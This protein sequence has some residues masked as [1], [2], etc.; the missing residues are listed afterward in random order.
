MLGDRKRVRRALAVAV[1][2]L[3]AGI[4]PAVAQTATTEGDAGIPLKPTAQCPQNDIDQLQR[5]ITFVRSK[6]WAEQPDSTAFAVS[7]DTATCRVVLKI[8]KV[9]SQEETALQ[10]A[11]EGRLSIQL[12]KDHPKPSRLPLILWVVFGGPGLVFLFARYG[13][14]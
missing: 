7:P 5:V 2:G 11:G 6:S 4:G 3:M 14:A 13:R 8:N 9:S 12:L 10:R 1:L